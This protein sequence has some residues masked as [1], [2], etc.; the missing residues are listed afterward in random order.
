[1]SASLQQN[2]VKCGLCLSVCPV[3]KVLAQE[4]A[5][6]RA[7]IQLIKFFESGRLAS[8]AGLK[9]MISRC[10]MCGSCAAN[11]PSGIDHYA[12]FMKMRS[13]MAEDHGEPV[14]VKSLVFLLAKEYRIRWAA[15]L[16][17]LGQRLIPEKFSETYNLGNI[18]VKRLPVFNTRPFRQAV[19]EIR[20]PKGVQ[21][22]RVV[23]F[24][25][26]ATNYLFDRTGF[27]TLTVLNRMG[28][29]VIIP[30]NQTCC[31]IPLLYHGAV[32]QA[33]ENVI[34]NMNCLDHGD[35]EAVIVDC[36]TCGAALKNEYPALQDRFH[37]DAKQVEGIS[38]KVVDIMTFLYFR[39]GLDQ[40]TGIEETVTATYHL[41]C[42]MKN[43][44][45]GMNTTEQ[46]LDALSF[47]RYRRAQD[48]H[49][50]C[51]G[52]GTFFQEY[53]G[54]SKVMADQKVK[55]AVSTQARY[56]LTE[57][58]VCRINLSGNLSETDRI[59]V[60]HPVEIVTQSGYD[61]EDLS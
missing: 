24:T 42:H 35:I 30:K 51:G 55:N 37:L 52:G 48:A 60:R 50:C 3:Y 13:Q 45:P 1:M 32:N 23:Y 34:K 38:S 49:D 43:G 40:F 12:R 26:C 22:G 54:L 5:S 2:C 59:T 25:G 36:P 4:Q 6:P 14:A 33:K 21:K 27:S 28:Y 56:W 61:N 47:V 19:P 58:P 11:C 18:P 9:E 44:L 41:P 7:R 31:G 15:G 29:E 39:N 17:R 10:L 46:I 53:P 20:S 8:S 57:C 16:A